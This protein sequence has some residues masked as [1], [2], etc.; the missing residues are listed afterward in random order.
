MRTRTRF[1]LAPY[2][3]FFFFFYF[4]AYTR[5]QRLRGLLLREFF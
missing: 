3:I 2:R 1:S 5:R 4:F